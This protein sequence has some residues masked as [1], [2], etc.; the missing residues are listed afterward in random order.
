MKKAALI[1]LA[2][3]ILLAVLVAM[4]VAAYLLW[5]LPQEIGTVTVNGK[6]IDWSGAHAGHWALATLGILLAV[7]IV[8]VVVPLAA[9]AVF[10][11]PLTMTALGLLLAAVAL[12][13]VLSPLWLLLWWLRKR[14]T[15][16]S[17]IDA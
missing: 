17:T 2:G 12:G 9:V 3:A 1:V 16:P 10:I 14:R 7:V 11:V 6:V 15:Q 8:A 13:L 4:A 5:G